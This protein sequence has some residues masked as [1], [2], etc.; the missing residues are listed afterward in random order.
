MRRKSIVIALCA[1]VLLTCGVTIGARS[2]RVN[3]QPQNCNVSKA[4]GT[5]RAVTAESWLLF[6]DEKGTLR[7]VDYA[8]HVQR[9]INRQ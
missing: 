9:A 8:C 4:F 6:E 1:A 5:F 3:A 2:A 7:A